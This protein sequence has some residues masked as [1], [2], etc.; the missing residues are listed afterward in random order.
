MN[1]VANA[2]PLRSGSR[3]TVG[4]NVSLEVV[5]GVLDLVDVVLVIVVGVNVKIGDVVT[6][7]SHVLLATRFSCTARV[8]GAHVCRNLAEDVTEGHLVLPHLLL[9]VNGGDGAQVQMSPGVGSDMMTLR[10]HALDDAG[11]LRSRV[12]F[13]LVDVVASDEESR[14]SIVGLEDVKNVGGVV[15]LWAIIVG[16]SNCA[17]G[18]AIVDTGATVLNRANL[19]AGN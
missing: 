1:V 2:Q 9:A 17:R 12:D 8:R 5:L 4:S 6:E 14:L 11:E 7:I 13:S 18:D 19:G 16:Q 3:S 15:L 10:V